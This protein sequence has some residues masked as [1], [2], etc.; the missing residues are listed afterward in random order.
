MLS[1]LYQQS[2]SSG[3]IPIDWKRA[4][5]CPIWVFILIRV[6]DCDM[7]FIALISCTIIFDVKPWVELLYLLVHCR[8]RPK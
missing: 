6:P 1:H 3:R 5:V 8:L 4:N 7:T 2:L